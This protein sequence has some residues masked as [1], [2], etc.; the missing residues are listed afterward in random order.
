[1][2]ANREDQHEGGRQDEGVR[3]GVGVL[4]SAGVRQDDAPMFQGYQLYGDSILSRMT[5]LCNP[6][7]RATYDHRSRQK[8]IGFIAHGQ[9]VCQLAKAIRSGR[10]NVTDKAIVLIG[11]NDILKVDQEDKTK[12][13]ISEIIEM[14]SSLEEVLILTIPPVPRSCEN[15]DLRKQKVEAFNSYLKEIVLEKENI[16]IIDVHAKFLNEEGEANLDLYNKNFSIS[17]MEDLIHPNREGMDLIVESLK[18]FIST[19]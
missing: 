18:D 4:Q 16:H 19:S 8:R 12:E 9:T 11:T 17:G 13:G 10:S 5:H 6:P 1:M 2:A 14:L 7:V 15:P 3:Q